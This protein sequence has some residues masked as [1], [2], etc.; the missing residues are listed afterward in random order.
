MC[1]ALLTLVAGMA[2]CGQG[3]LVFGG[4]DGDREDTVEV[5][6]NIRDFSPQVAG[7]D[8]VVFVFTGLQ[9]PGT[10]QVFAKQRATAVDTA[11]EPLEFSVSRIRA[12]DLTVVFLRDS[13]SDPDGTI[14]AGDPV[15][16][17]SDPDGRLRDV[18]NG[19][20]IEVTDIDIDFNAGR[21]DAERIRTVRD[22]P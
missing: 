1:S 20:R 15:A 22:A 2:A 14:D 10:Y 8:I 11:G 16:T 3:T 19:E 13:A 21:A 9:D 18:R 7:A 17:L 5:R 4:G 12:G 6:G